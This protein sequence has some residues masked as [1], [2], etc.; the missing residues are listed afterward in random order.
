MSA[1]R[2]AN[3]GFGGTDKDYAGLFTDCDPTKVDPFKGDF[4]V[5][6]SL[7]LDPLLKEARK[8]RADFLKEVPMKHTIPQI[9]SSPDSDDRKRKVV[10]ES[11]K[12]IENFKDKLSNYPKHLSYE[13]SMVI[14]VMLYMQREVNVPLNSLPHIDQQLI[15]SIVPD[16]YKGFSSLVVKFDKE[17]DFSVS[18]TPWKSDEGKVQSF[19]FVLF[20]TVA[21]PRPEDL[22]DVTQ[23]TVE[24][25]EKEGTINVGG[26]TIVLDKKRLANLAQLPSR[27]EQGWRQSEP[28]PPSILKTTNRNA[29]EIRADVLQMAIDWAK[30]NESNQR[31]DDQLLDLAKKFYTFV[32]D[33]NRR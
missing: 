23:G 18:V 1:L 19:S 15:T 11:R 9:S 17:K 28:E 26:S 7:N 2:E 31:S 32:E 14:C 4:R 12:M 27:D 10:E 22:K 6:G 13:G 25:E 33:R 16:N 5:T 20:N 29:Y 8:L 3:T 24:V 30:N 21:H